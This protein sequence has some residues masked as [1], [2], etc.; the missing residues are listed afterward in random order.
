MKKTTSLFLLG[1]LLLCGCSRNYTITT[2]SGGQ[3][4]ARGKPRLSDGAYV[5]K[6]LQGRTATV[7]AGRVREIAPS[8]MVNNPS[9]QY[10]GAR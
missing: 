9:D 4:A 5:Y 3:I 2:N 7:P 8:S 1:G 10:R 6:D